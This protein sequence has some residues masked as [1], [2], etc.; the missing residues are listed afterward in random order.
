[1][2]R[3]WLRKCLVEKM[4]FG[5]MSSWENVVWENFGLRKCQ[6]E[7]LSHWEYALLRKCFLRKCRW[8]NVVWERLRL[9]Y[10]RLGN[11]R[12]SS[13]SYLISLIKTLFRWFKFHFVDEWFFP[14]MHVNARWS[15][16]K[17]VDEWFFSLIKHFFVDEKCFR[18]WKK[19]SLMKYFFVDYIFFRWLKNFSLMIAD[20]T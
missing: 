11:C 15:T 1:M 10:G 7:I 20:S 5:N 12:R 3:V 9:R 8:E 4:S 18:W 2:S 6:F 19:F 16:L 13:L 14:L 17:H